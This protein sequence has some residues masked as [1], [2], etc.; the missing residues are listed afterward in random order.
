MTGEVDNKD[1]TLEVSLLDNEHGFPYVSAP[2]TEE[3]MVVGEIRVLY[4]GEL[5][6]K[7]P[8]ITKDELLP[9]GFFKTGFDFLSLKYKSLSK[10]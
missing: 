1:V 2:I 8:L 3:A 9:S 6:R 5:V 10:G 7:V 4:K